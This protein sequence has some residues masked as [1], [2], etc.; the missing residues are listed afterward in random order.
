MVTDLTGVLVNISSVRI[1]WSLENNEFQFL[2]GKFRTFTV[3]I[4]ENLSKNF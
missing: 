2:N 4:Y 3:M 1:T